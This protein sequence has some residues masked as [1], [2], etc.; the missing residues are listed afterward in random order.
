MPK[1]S[2]SDIKQNEKVLCKESFSCMYCDVSFNNRLNLDHHLDSKSCV[3]YSS[4]KA[5][6]PSKEAILDR[7]K[8][9][10]CTKCDKFFLSSDELEY[11]MGSTPAQ[12]EMILGI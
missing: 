11:H 9:F 2:K 4:E 12:N 3:V 6:M 1:S 8:P 5:T 10:S 7:E